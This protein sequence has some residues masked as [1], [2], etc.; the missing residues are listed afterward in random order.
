MTLDEEQKILLS[1]VETWRLSEKPEYRGFRCAN[2][3]QYKNKARYHWVNTAGCKFPIHMCDD[4][5]EPEFQNNS[6]VVDE[7]KRQPVDRVFW[8]FISL[9]PKSHKTIS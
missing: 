4:T 5:C 2:C 9:Y 1:I 7:S 8:N 3:Q 6:I